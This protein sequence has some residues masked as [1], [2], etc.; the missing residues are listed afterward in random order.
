MQV[1]LA[2]STMRIVKEV[3]EKMN[4]RK[5]V[6]ILLAVVLGNLT[7]LEKPSFKSILG[8]SRF[9]EV[10]NNFYTFETVRFCILSETYN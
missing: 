4:G 9:K 7:M 8:R 10:S 2:F 6:N 1:T 5:N 3:C